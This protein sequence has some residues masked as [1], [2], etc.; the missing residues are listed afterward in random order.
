MLEAGEGMS[1]GGHQSQGRLS[2]GAVARRVV[3]KEELALFLASTPSGYCR[4]RS[5]SCGPSAFVF[6]S[7]PDASHCPAFHPAAIQ[8]LFSRPARRMSFFSRKK[9]TPQSA[10]TA[11]AVPPPSGP[12]LPQQQQVQQPSQKQVTKEASYERS[13]SATHPHSPVSG[14]S[15]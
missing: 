11:N 1:E 3:R 9:H 12:S 8:S 14:P 5:S 13:V 10:S 4:P 6:P 2:A 15:A 7:A